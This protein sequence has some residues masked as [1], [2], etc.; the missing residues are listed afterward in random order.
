MS[1]GS[2]FRTVNRA[3][4]RR[5]GKRFVRP[6]MRMRVTSAGPYRS[7]ARRSPAEAMPTGVRGRHPAGL[8]EGWGL[9]SIW[10]MAASTRALLLVA[11]FFSLMPKFVLVRTAT[12]RRPLASV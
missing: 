12:L 4:L 9:P 3:V 8:S 7:S 1:S 11:A 10:Q 5:R 6:L 2:A